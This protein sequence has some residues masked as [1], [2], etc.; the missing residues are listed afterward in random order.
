MLKRLQAA[1]YVEG[2]HISER[3]ELIGI[4]VELGL[5]AGAFAKAYDAAMLNVTEHFR[6]AQVLLEALG[7]R[8]YP[9][10]AIEQDGKLSRLHLGRYFGK[11]ELFRQ[12]LAELLA[13]AQSAN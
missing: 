1:Y 11:P 12:A 9:T 5:D 4:A 13:P 6:D 7:G 2:R 3:A 8:G 10:L